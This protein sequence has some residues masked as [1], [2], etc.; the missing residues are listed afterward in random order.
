[1]ANIAFHHVSLTCADTKATELFYVEHFDFVRARVVPFGETEIVFIRLGDMWLE[2]FQA[3][4]E[5]PAPKATSDAAPSER[6][7][8]WRALSWSTAYRFQ[9]GRCGRKARRDG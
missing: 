1:M 9:S 5:S 3:E 6:H 4:E 7:R 8:R 2:L